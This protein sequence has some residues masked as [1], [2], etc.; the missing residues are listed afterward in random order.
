MLERFVE[1]SPMAIMTRLVMQGAIHDEWLDAAAELD[2][3]PDG[4][5]IREALLARVVDALV[6][7]A[8][9]ARPAG[10]GLATAGA[11]SPEFAPT[12]TA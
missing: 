2:D 10:G 11:I 7:L 6:A 12:V 1:H 4:E 5:Q 8:A 3:E 9:S